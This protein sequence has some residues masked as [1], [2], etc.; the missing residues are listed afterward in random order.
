MNFEPFYKTNANF[1]K[2][3]SHILY[4]AKEEKETTS[5]DP[6]SNQ[7]N[8]IQNIEF[9]NVIYKTINLN[10]FFFSIFYLLVPTYIDITNNTLI[11]D[12]YENALRDYDYYD[13]F[14]LFQ[15]RY[16]LCNKQ[17][18]RN[19]LKQKNFNNIILQ[20]CS[21]YLDVNFIIFENNKMKLIYAKKPTP[22]K[23]HIILLK[24]NDNEYQPVFQEKKY[25]FTSNDQI[26]WIA[27][28]KFIMLKT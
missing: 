18:L 27:F 2:S 21:D 12:F 9:F 8:S 17:T 19:L 28:R 25:I 4:F 20:F 11:D 1:Y 6:Y 15:Y 7:N 10:N 16:H 13:L 14:K 23:A 22:Y 26:S 3:L 24:R 5:I